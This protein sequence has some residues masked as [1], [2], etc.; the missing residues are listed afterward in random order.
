MLMKFFYTG[1][2]S[3]LL[4]LGSLPGYAQYPGN[5]IPLTAGTRAD[6]YFPC[7]FSAFSFTNEYSYEELEV[8]PNYCPGNPIIPHNLQ[9]IGFTPQSSSVFVEVQAVAC[10]WNY[11]VQVGIWKAPDEIWPFLQ[12]VLPCNY[13]IPPYTPTHLYLN[14]LQPGDLYY[15]VFDGFDGDICEIQMYVESG[16]LNSGSLFGETSVSLDGNEHFQV[17]AGSDFSLEAA[18]V[19]NASIYNWTIDGEPRSNLREF[20]LS[21]EEAGSYEVCVTPMNSCDSLGTTVCETIEVFD[22]PE[23]STVQDTIVCGAYTL[24]PIEGSNLTGNENYYLSDDFYFWG[25]TPIPVGTTIDTS[26]SL[27]IFDGIE[28]YCAS[29]RFFDVEITQPVTPDTL[30]DQTGCNF[31]VFTAPDSSLQLPPVTYYSALNGNG[32]IFLPGDTTFSSGTYYRTF[33]QGACL[34]EQAFEVELSGIYCP[35][36]VVNIAGQTT[37]PDGTPISNTQISLQSFLPR[38]QSTDTGGHFAFD[39]IPGGFNYTLLPSRHQD[40]LD[41]VDLS[42]A[43]AIL[44]HVYGLETFYDTP[45]APYLL[46]AADVNSDQAV[47][48]AD[49]AIVRNTFMGLLDTFPAAPSWR[50]VPAG[51]IFNSPNNPWLDDFPERAILPNLQ[52]DTLVAF[53]GIKIGDVDFTNTAEGLQGG[54]TTQLCLPNPALRRGEKIT[55]PVSVKTDRLAGVQFELRYD[56]SRLSLLQVQPNKDLFPGQPVEELQPGQL[57]VMLLSPAMEGIAAGTTLLTLEFVANQPGQLYSGLEWPILARQAQSLRADGQ[58]SPLLFTDCD[59]VTVSTS[60]NID[61]PI[62]KIACLPNPFS[63]SATLSIHTPVEG[64]IEIQVF[65]PS[66]KRVRRLQQHYGAG[67]HHVTL[68]DWLPYSG[69]FLITVTN[70]NETARLWAVRM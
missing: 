1:L 63:T 2:L 20:E 23:L 68:E 32:D 70:Q 55:V 58:K 45:Q 22:L 6:A 35:D 15:F 43:F 27:V 59:Q 3:V 12:Y 34:A 8:P 18:P 62:L 17:C 19:F 42:D 5:P 47:T 46:I 38:T 29:T 26:V 31:F 51:F 50:F 48:I 64:P 11:G 16:F 14:N 39:S 9:W 21:I 37:K 49:F 10:Q 13:E 33:E 4:M 54:P 57:P 41:G 66:G 61:V 60:D 24:P 7:D 67:T 52:T 56:T 53:Y 40:V 36:G 30:A 44:K 69:S 65:T 25:S 28:N